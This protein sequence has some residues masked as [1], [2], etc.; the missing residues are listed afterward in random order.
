MCRVQRSDEVWLQLYDQKRARNGAVLGERKNVDMP[1]NRTSAFTAYHM[2]IIYVYTP[3]TKILCNPKCN[4]IQMNRG[5]CFE[6]CFWMFVVL[7][8]SPLWAIKNFLNLFVMITIY[9]RRYFSGKYVCFKCSFCDNDTA[10]LSY[11]T[12]K[13]PRVFIL[14]IKNFV[15]SFFQL[16]QWTQRE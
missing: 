4:A 1:V 3:R 5:F 8:L 12:S 9:L 16:H 6:Q 14:D 2:L 10:L 13:L 7:V 15:F 11:K